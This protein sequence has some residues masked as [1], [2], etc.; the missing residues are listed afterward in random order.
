[1]GKFAFEIACPVRI[2]DEEGSWLIVIN[3]E[4]SVGGCNSYELRDL[5]DGSRPLQVRPESSLRRECFPKTKCIELFKK[6]GYINPEMEGANFYN[7]HSDNGWLIKR[8]GR[9]AP[10]KDINRLADTWNNNAIKFGKPLKQVE[11]DGL[12]TNQMKGMR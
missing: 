11:A 4:S 7:Y 9:A 2:D 8:L 1:M 3:R 10:I 12:R 6:K 5:L